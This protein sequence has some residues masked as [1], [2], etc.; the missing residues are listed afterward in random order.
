[1]ALFEDQQGTGQNEG[2]GFGLRL[3]K[4][5]TEAFRNDVQPRAQQ[6]VDPNDPYSAFDTPAGSPSASGFGD[7]PYSAF[8]ESKP[9]APKDQQGDFSR[10]LSVSG[11][12]LK[13]TAYGTAALIG[14]TLGADKLKDWG[15][16]GYKDAEQEVQAI[17]KQSDSFTNAVESGELGKWFKYSTGYLLGQVAELG[18]ASLAGAAVGTA[19]APGAG[20]AAGAVAGAVEKG[21]VQAGVRSFVGKMIDKQAAEAAERLVKAGVA[22]EVAEKVAVEQATKSV[23]RTIG[24]TTANT[25]LNATQELGSIYGDAVEEAALKGQ[26]YSLGRVWLAGMAATA[27]DSWADS[28]ALGKFMGALGGDQKIRGVAMEALKGGFREGMTEGVQTAIERWGADKDLAS[29]EAFKEYI[30]SAAVGVLGGGIAGGTSGAI[31]KFTTP[32]EPKPG[33]TRDPQGESILGASE[34]AAGDLRDTL[35]RNLKGITQNELLDT[36]NNMDAVAF[37][38]STATPEQQKSLERAIQRA[39]VLDQF[40]EAKGNKEFIDRGAQLFA[41][42][43]VALDDLRNAIDTFGST[44]NLQRRVKLPKRQTVVTEED[45][46]NR[47]DEADAALNQGLS[48]TPPNQEQAG[49][50]PGQGIRFST[51]KV[52]VSRQAPVAPAASVTPEATSLPAEQPSVPTDRSSD[53]PKNPI[54]FSPAPEPGR[55]DLGGGKALNATGKLD[56]P[57]EEEAKVEPP[58]PQVKPESGPDFGAPTERG[59]LVQDI[60]ERLK[61]VDDDKVVDKVKGLLKVGRIEQ[62]D[63]AVAEHFKKKS[64]PK[65]DE[66]NRAKL[67]LGF[68][69]K[70]KSIMKVEESGTTKDADGKV[71]NVDQKISELIENDPTDSNVKTALNLLDWEATRVMRTFLKRGQVKAAQRV[72]DAMDLGYKKVA[73]TMQR[74]RYSLDFTEVGPEERTYT[75]M[76]DPN[77]KPITKAALERVPNIKRYIDSLESKGEKYGASLDMGGLSQEDLSKLD[78]AWG[79]YFQKSD[80]VANTLKNQTK[81]DF[82]KGELT[83]PQKRLDAKFSEIVNRFTG[84]RLV[85]QGL[86]RLRER[87]AD[88]DEQIAEF[89]SMTVEGKKGDQR[90]NVRRNDDPLAGLFGLYDENQYALDEEGFR[91]DRKITDRDLLVAERGRLSRELQAAMQEGVKGKAKRLELGMERLKEALLDA[92]KSATQSGSMSFQDVAE[93]YGKYRQYTEFLNLLDATDKLVAAEKK[94]L[95]DGGMPAAQAESEARAKYEELQQSAKD[96][97]EEAASPK[98]TATLDMFE[99]EKRVEQ[100]AAGEISANE[101]TEADIPAVMGAMARQLSQAKGKPEFQDKLTAVSTWIAQNM[102]TQSLTFQ[103]VMDAFRSNGVEMPTALLNNTHLAVHTRMLDYSKA[104]GGGYAPREFWLRSMDQALQFNPALAESGAFTDAEL[105]MHEEWKARQEKLAARRKELAESNDPMQAIEGMLFA[106]HGLAQM[107]NPRLIASDRERLALTNGINDLVEAWHR[108]VKLALELHPELKATLTDPEDGRI[109]PTDWQ[110]HQDWLERQRKIDERKAEMVLKSQYHL[111]LPSLQGLTQDQMDAL[112]LK[113]AAADVDSL[114]SILHTANE[115][116][117]ANRFGEGTRVD[118]ETGEIISLAEEAR[119]NLLDDLLLQDQS[120]SNLAATYGTRDQR[121]LRKVR[122]AIDEGIDD[123]STREGSFARLASES[124]GS[125]ALPELADLNDFESQQQAAEEAEGFSGKKAESQEEVSEDPDDLRGKTGFFSGRLT[126]GVVSAAVSRL[127]QGWKTANQIVVLKNVSQLPDGLRERVMDKLDGREAKGL[128]DESTGITYLF[129]DMLDSDADVEFTLFHETYGHFGLRGFLGEKFDAFLE[130]MYRIYPNVRREADALIEQGVAKLE[131][132]DEA[133]SDIAA[134]NENLPAVKVWVGRMIAG[135]REIGFNRVADWMSGITNAELAFYLKG[136]R[137]YAKNGGYPI[138]NGAPSDV[139]FKIAMHERLYEMFS[140]GGNK[141]AAYARFNPA[142][143]TWAVFTADKD[144]IRTGYSAQVMS[145]Y[146]DVLDYMRKNGKVEFRKRSGMYVEDKLPVDMPKLSEVTDIQGVKRWMRGMITKYQNEY[147]PVFDVVEFLKRKGVLTEAMDVKTALQLYERKIGAIIDDFRRIYVKP[148]YQL[149][150]EAGKQGADLNK[151]EEFLLARHAAERNAA[152]AKI[153]PS[154]TDGSGMATDKAMQILRDVAKEP[155]YNTLLEI[156]DITDKMSKEKLSYLR[157][158]GMITAQDYKKMSQYRHYVNLSGIREDLDKFDDVNQLVGNRFNVKG[159]EQRAK[160]RSGQATD[161]VANTILG[162]EAALIRGQKNVVAQKILA[163]LEANYDPNFAV[164]NEIQYE[165]QIGEDGLVME[166]EKADYIKDKTVM[167]AKVNGIP[168]TIRFK[169]MD[170]GSFG[171]AVFGMVYPTPPGEIMEKLGRFNQVIGQMLTTWNPA[172][173]A[174]NSVRDAQTLYFN[175]AADGRITKA[176]AA[177]MVRMLPK[178]IKTAYYMAMSEAGKST[179]ITPDPELVKMYLEMKRGGGMTSFLNRKDLESQVKEIEKILSNPSKLEQ[180]K[181]KF[182]SVL[183]IMEFLSLPAEIAPR[184]AAY[185]VVRQGGFSKEQ[186][187]VFSGEI[188]VNFN[189]RG[190]TKWVRQAYLFF[191]PAVQGSAKLLSLFG[192]IG[193]DYK[194]KLKAKGFSYVAALIGLGALANLFARA[195][196]D[197]DEA[198]R[199]GLDKLPV[200]KRA[201]SLVLWADGPA[202]PIPYGWNA[203]YAMGHFA[204]DSMLGIQ[205]M[206]V[207]TKRIAQATFESFSPLGSAGLDSNTLSGTIVKGIAPTATLPMIEWM[208]N[209]NRFGAPIRREDSLFGGAKRPDSEM[210]FRSASPIS[211]S[212]A[213]GLNELTGGNRA[214][215]GAVDFNPALIDHLIGAYLPGLMNEG[216]KAASVAIRVSGGEDVKNMSY[217]IVDRFRAKIPESYD[218]GAFRRA[219]ELIETRYQEFKEFP[220]NR[221]EILRETPGLR[222]AHAIVAS[223]TQEI[224]KLRSDLTEYENRKGIS[225]E[226]KV[227]KLNRTREREA[228]IYARAVKAVMEAGPE[229]REAVMASD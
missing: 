41:D 48:T 174:I 17:S 53:L 140:V 71:K 213:K 97:E 149:I 40:Q 142:T 139:R 61:N 29:K 203:F 169:D 88:L 186:A 54:Q 133:M 12:Q 219:K 18:V 112:K 180:A 39:D 178:A 34:K 5:A 7:D 144:D 154:M 122:R 65:K 208:L 24:A 182:K 184:L 2:G 185:T 70:A 47:M 228:Q 165:R 106:K 222:K 31:N 16:K 127:T 209:E 19:A 75:K 44:R 63:A 159:K 33:E 200:W 74:S 198:G 202:I 79:R 26:E 42:S 98:D 9:A 136:A 114:D 110:A 131:A 93:V 164:I 207:S 221:S 183:D 14:D 210:A 138:A 206:S 10:G 32:V 123:A 43:P 3:F 197:D 115:M 55:L 95:M 181:D 57:A 121:E 30:D 49:E 220:E 51:R 129:S 37:L 119:A 13:Q 113:I 227:A 152:V 111:Y 146:E 141:T 193:P 83:E 80:A 189:M 116:A 157:N 155:Y 50:Q 4:S 188:T 216:Y 117:Q 125:E 161:I 128:F 91:S 101:I 153:N 89:D 20:T 27:V 163:L 217:P 147:R 201:T 85:G 126:H 23:Y 151:I 218:S 160:G 22:K 173:V 204:M 172:W 175:A 170:P 72:F 76:T 143:Q 150:D 69:R 73:E 100:M 171:N 130:N 66:L 59:K 82:G 68:L 52:S 21:A 223:A 1:M 214:R 179:N 194:L 15:L 67:N 124:R 109:L 191:N 211:D 62:A 190:S 229:F 107:R 224:R 25:F 215:A 205:P 226:D 158:T 105:L 196:S 56:I 86:E 212:I 167:V 187:A 166:V 96:F 199:N 87:I 8:M 156:G 28:K 145:R 58:K 45:A 36:L 104:N 90:F 162:M 132:I 120:T 177:Q 195:M 94:A 64:Q 11:K 108:D 99:A 92:A 168:T 77:R 84:S 192:D 148:L 135:L 176:Q 6:K 102:R 103:Q 225:D 35:P 134:K 137:D 118:P 38:Y 78:Q 81:I 60:Q 46:M